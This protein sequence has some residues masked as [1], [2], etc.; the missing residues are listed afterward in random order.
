MT[1]Q[2]A[3]VGGGFQVTLQGAAGAFL[4]QELEGK[5][6]IPA[7]RY[8]VRFTCDSLTALGVWNRSTI[9]TPD[10]SKDNNN[11]PGFGPH[12][13]RE[14]T[15]IRVTSHEGEGQNFFAWI[16][17][18]GTATKAIFLIHPVDDNG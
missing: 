11:K 5:R 3:T 6:N 17:P 13:G 10:F 4:Q 2:L 7:G 1:V 12:F 9:N 8:A 18:A 16:D 15:I 14:A